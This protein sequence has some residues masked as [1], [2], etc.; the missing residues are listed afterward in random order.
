ME[1]NSDAISHYALAPALRN[2]N[3]AQRRVAMIGYDSAQT[4]LLPAYHVHRM[5]ADTPCA[6]VLATTATDGTNGLAC[7]TA[8]GDVVFRAA[9]WSPKP[10]ITTFQLTGTGALPTAVTATTVKGTVPGA[11]SPLEVVPETAA[12][13]VA[14]KVSVVLPMYSFTVLKF[15]GVL[16]AHPASSS[17]AHSSGTTVHSSE[18]GHVPASSAAAKSSEATSGSQHSK[19]HKAESAASCIG[20]TVALL[21][22]ALSLRL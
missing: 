20:A 13:P 14:R 15:E 18:S 2:N 19:S 21:A 12:L 22:G 10:L 4:Y 9:N 6:A 16:N 3:G 5:A 8:A 1:R 7:S 17:H 11:Y